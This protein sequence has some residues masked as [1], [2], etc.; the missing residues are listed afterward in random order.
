MMIMKIVRLM[1]AQNDLIMMDAAAWVV[2]RGHCCLVDSSK[3]LNVNRF[4]MF[5]PQFLLRKV[6]KAI[7]VCF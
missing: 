2:K 1:W 4:I 6:G 3:N 7:A 5:H